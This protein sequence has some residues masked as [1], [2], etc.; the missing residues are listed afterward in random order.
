VKYQR[1]YGFTSERIDYIVAFTVELFKLK[2]YFLS[3]LG[4]DMSV[5]NYNGGCH[6]ATTT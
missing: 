2:P 4:V 3:L 5:V 6:S 1:W